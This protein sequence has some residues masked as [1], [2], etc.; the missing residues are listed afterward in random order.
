M[1]LCW[2]GKYSA[3]PLTFQKSRIGKT[4]EV[5]NIKEGRLEIWLMNVCRFRIGYLDKGFHNHIPIICRNTGSHLASSWGDYP[6]AGPQQTWRFYL[7]S[8][9]NERKRSK[10]KVFY[11]VVQAK[12]FY[13]RL[14]AKGNQCN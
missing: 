9:V 11:G 6:L 3:T 12:C 14:L 4:K 8:R 10:Y 1:S 13:G 5:T 7:Q 2:T